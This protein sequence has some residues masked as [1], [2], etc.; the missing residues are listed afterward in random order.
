[1]IFKIKPAG[2]A[3]LGIS[4]PAWSFLSPDTYLC[5]FPCKMGFVNTLMQISDL[6]KPR[7]RASPQVLKLLILILFVLL[8]LKIRARHRANRITKQHGRQICELPGDARVSK[9]AFR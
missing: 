3:P 5:A 8:V 1:M 9:F 4:I 6:E 2:W 7:L